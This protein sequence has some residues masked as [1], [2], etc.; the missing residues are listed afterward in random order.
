ME[1]NSK[2]LDLVIRIV[3]EVIL[4]YSTILIFY[5]IYSI[6]LIKIHIYIL[7]VLAVW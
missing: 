3:Q 7:L 4:S 5:I 2:V 6:F 1:Y